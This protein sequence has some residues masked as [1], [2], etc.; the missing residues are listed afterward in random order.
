LGS[1]QNT[2]KTTNQAPMDPFLS[3]NQSGFNLGSSNPNNSTN[4]LLIPNSNN[5]NNNT[6]NNNDP[7][8]DLW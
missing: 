4:P 7:F 6:K 1:N 8:S 5:N 2:N 3:L